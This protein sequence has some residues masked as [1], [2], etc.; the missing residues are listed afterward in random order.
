MNRKKKDVVINPT[1]ATIKARF[2]SPKIIT[3]YVNNYQKKYNIKFSIEELDEFKE[4]IYE[5]PFLALEHKVGKKIYNFFKKVYEKDYLDLS[6]GMNFYRGRKRTPDK[7]TYGKDDLWNPRKG[8]SSQGRYNLMGGEVLYCCDNIIGIPYELNYAKNETID[9]AIL[10]TQKELRIAY[11]DLL[12][13]GFEVHFNEK[14]LES[15]SLKKSYILTNFIKDCCKHLGFNGV[16]YQGLSNKA[17]Y[18]NIAFFNFKKNEDITI[19]DD[20]KSIH[21]EITY[22]E[23]K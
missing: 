21:Y 15:T 6:I 9:I 7:P 3:E 19:K 8:Y 11:I 5:N 23:I 13:E 1:P 4:Y 17:T 22:E 10:E 14:N 2:H 12:L 18:Y 20:I 16:L